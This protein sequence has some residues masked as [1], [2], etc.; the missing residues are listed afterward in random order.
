MN[1]AAPTSTSWQIW[2]YLALCGAAGAAILTYLGRV[3]PKLLERRLHGPAAEAE[4]SQK[5]IQLAAVIVFAGTIVLSSFDRRS[6][7]SHFPPVAAVV[8]DVLVAVCFLVI[9]LALRENTFAAVNI[10]VEEDQQV[11]S[12]GPYAVVRHPYYS[13]LLV[14]CCATPLALGSFWG[15]LMLVPMGLVIASRIRFEE[16]FLTEHLH[17]YA[18]YCRRVRYR[19]LPRVW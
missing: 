12:T 11:I 10:A 15:M 5:L 7:W 2:V 17:G 1:L 19:L 16:R 9:F 3:D 8:G 6:S 18:A 14:W 13:G 4:T